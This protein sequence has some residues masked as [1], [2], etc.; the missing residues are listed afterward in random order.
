MH[1][2]NSTT[3]VHAKVPI[4]RKLTKPAHVLRKLHYDCSWLSIDQKTNKTH[5]LTEN[6]TTTV[7]GK[8]PMIRKLTKPHTLIY[9]Y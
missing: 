7:H 1:T 9:T 3:N 6:S 4:Q 2:E 5:T 8:V